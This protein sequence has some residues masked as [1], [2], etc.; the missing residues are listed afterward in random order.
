M[1]AS[2]DS[3]LLFQVAKLDDENPPAAAVLRDLEKVDHTGKA[4]APSQVRRYVCQRDLPQR[5]H[6][7]LT[8]RESV[9]SSH[10]DARLLPYPDAAGDFAAPDPVTQGL[11]ELHSLLLLGGTA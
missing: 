1:T 10:S 7:D 11:Y 3:P 6:H 2:L 8:R 5:L 4:T 9:P